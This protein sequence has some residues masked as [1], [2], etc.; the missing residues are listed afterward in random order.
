MQKKNGSVKAY[1]NGVGKY[2]NP[3]LKRSHEMQSQESETAS[4]KKSKSCRTS[5]NFTSW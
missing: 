5:F 2:L 4:K 1:S 3:S